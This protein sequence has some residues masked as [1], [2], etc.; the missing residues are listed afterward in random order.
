LR[1]NVIPAVFW[2][3]LPFGSSASSGLRMIDELPSTS[4]GSTEMSG[5]YYRSPWARSS[6]REE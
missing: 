6:R 3:L 2:P 5:S 4:S 1:S